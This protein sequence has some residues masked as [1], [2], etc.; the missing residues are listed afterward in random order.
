ML[1]VDHEG[2]PAGGRFIIK[3]Q[4]SVLAEIVYEYHSPGIIAAT[5]TRVDDSLK[6][7]GIGRKLLD[8]LAAMA[9]EHNL[10]IVPVCSF[11]SAAME[12]DENLGK[13]KADV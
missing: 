9:K 8:R 4:N 1:P 11:V 3:D 6:G 13:L 7:Q 2:T 10:K 12:K 5:H